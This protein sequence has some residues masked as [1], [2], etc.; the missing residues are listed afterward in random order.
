MT[1]S[2][3]HRPRRW[4]EK[5]GDAFR[6][7]YLGVRSQSS[8]RVHLPAAVLVI[9]AAA[10]LGCDRLEW[11][12]LLGCIGAVCVAELFNSA[13]EELF[14]GLDEPTKARISGC[15]DMAAG[16]VLL[17]AATSVAIGAIVFLPRILVLLK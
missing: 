7:V 15:L 11:A 14:H 2:P 16:A 13:M 10:G 17:A 5:F 6:G 3:Q 12:L 9:I 1:E 4:R 8:F